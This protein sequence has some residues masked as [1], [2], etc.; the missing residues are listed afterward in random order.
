MTDLYVE[1]T[2]ITFDQN[3]ELSEVGIALGGQWGW[4]YC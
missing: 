1:V 3:Y 2:F 4:L